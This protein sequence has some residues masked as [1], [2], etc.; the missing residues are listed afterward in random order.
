M[1]VLKLNRETLRNLSDT[2]L[3]RVRAGE[4]PWMLEQRPSISCDWTFPNCPPR[5]LFNCLSD[6]C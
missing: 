2:D 5:T 6:Q 3:D 1:M 4:G